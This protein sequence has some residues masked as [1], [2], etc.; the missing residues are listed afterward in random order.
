MKAWELLS[1]DWKKIPQNIRYLLIFGSFL[2]SLT[3]IIDHWGTGHVYTFWGLD[4]REPAFSIGLTLI[5]LGI[6][7]PIVKQFLYIYDLI[8]YRKRY[9]IKNLGISY[10]LVWFNDKLILFDK[11]SK[12]HHHVHPFETAQDLLFV[13]KGVY[14][15]KNFNE[16]DKLLK[17]SE[18]ETLDMTRYKKG[19]PISTRG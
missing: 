4:I 6:L 2:I 11:S 12:T 18:N 13:G 17:I 9:P 16:K 5:F 3:W 15:K 8:L 19:D 10:I 7:L 14:L 1:D